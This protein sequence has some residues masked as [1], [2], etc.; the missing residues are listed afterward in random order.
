M[1]RTVR[2]CIFVGKFNMES[3]H[4][5]MNSIKLWP[6]SQTTRLLLVNRIVKHFTTPSILSR[7]YGLLTKEEV[8]EEAKQIESTGFL[9]A[10]QQFEKDPES[11]GG[12]SVQVYAKESSK[13][14]VEFIKT[15]PRPKEER[16]TVPELTKSDHVFDISGAHVAA[17]V[18]SGVKDKLTEVDLSD[19][20]SR[21]PEPEAV[22]VMKMFSSA[23]EGCG[24]SYLNLSNNGLGEKGVIAF[25]D[26]LRSQGNLVELYLMNAGISPE[27]A[28][29]VC[30][31]IPSTNKLKV[32]HFHHNKTG[33]EGAIAISQLVKGSPNL[34]DFRC[35][36][37]RVG[38]VG[39]VALAEALKTCTLLKKLDLRDNT[40]GPKAGVALSNNLSVHANLTEIYL[41]YL[42]LENEG[43]IAIANA[44]KT[45]K[46]ALE[47]I[48]MAGNKITFKAANALADCMVSKKHSLTKIN[49]SENELKDE[50]AIAIGKALEDDFG[51]LCIVDLSANGL[52]SDG[53]MSLAK[54]V[55]GKLGFRLLNINGNFLSYKGIEGVKEIFKNFPRM[56]G[57]LD[58]NDPHGEGD[59]D[60]DGRDNFNELKS[61]QKE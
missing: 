19:I 47:I 39:G 34:E 3:P 1:L 48:E 40:F 27:A 45:S 53:A 20:V 50:G 22:E 10:T 24:L 57:P 15:G 38:S 18:L 60:E 61:K 28:K 17:S 59:D 23:L 55:S 9:A 42:N 41:S 35:S 2:S 49:L 43:T 30:E 56:L 46:S 25:G 6:P 8:E 4:G 31:L 32:L 14:M 54:A 5:P 44:L 21:R 12:S 29:A 37:T 51:R 33:D 26:L 36:S 58:E 11:D 13:L 16:E 52:R 7:K